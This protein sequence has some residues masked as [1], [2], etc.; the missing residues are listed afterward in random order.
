MTGPES[1]VS[2]QKF[3]MA[4]PRKAVNLRSARPGSGSATPD[5]RVDNAQVDGFETFSNIFQLDTTAA[6]PDP[7]GSA[8][9]IFIKFFLGKMRW[10][11]IRWNLQ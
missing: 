2:G 4:G 10:F 6:D 3:S 9:N 7:H 11:W 8:F 1:A 5:F